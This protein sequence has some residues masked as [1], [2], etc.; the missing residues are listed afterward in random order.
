L[1]DPMAGEVAKTKIGSLELTEG[2]PFGCIPV[3]RVLI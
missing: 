1:N 3:L 2:E